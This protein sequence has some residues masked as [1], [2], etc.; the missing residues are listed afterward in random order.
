M[1][2]NRQQEVNPLSQFRVALCQDRT[3]AEQIRDG[4]LQT[5]IPA[6]IHDEPWQ[7]RLWYVSKR[8]AGI[9]V[10]VPSRMSETALVVLGA[11]DATD[12]ALRGAIRC[13]ECNSTL[14]D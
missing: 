12:G 4:L 1:G 5:G 7:A 11:W 9:R 10:E 13:P 2:V 6:R 8:S 14:V 3:A